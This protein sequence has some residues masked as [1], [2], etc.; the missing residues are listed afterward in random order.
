MRF[1]WL[2]K[3]PAQ[4]CLLAGMLA[5]VSFSSTQ[6]ALTPAGTHIDNRADGSYLNAGGGTE[7]FSSGTVKVIVQSLDLIEL[8]TNRTV[9]ATANSPVSFAHTLRNLGNGTTT[10]TVSFSN[11]TGD[12]FD[13]TDLALYRDLNG[14]GLADAGEPLLS[15]AARSSKAAAASAS[16]LD[17][18]ITLTLGAAESVNLILAA[19]TPASGLPGQSGQLQLLA[20]VEGQS[21]QAVNTDTVTLINITPTI[22]LAKAASATTASRNQK[23]TFTL[24]GSNSDGGTAMGV[25]V[26]IDGTN[27]SLVVI[28]DA[29]PRNTTFAA[30]ADAGTSRVLYHYAGEAFHAYHTVPAASLNL[31][32]AVGFDYASIPV[33]ESFSVAFK[34][35]VN[36]AASGGFTNIAAIHYFDGVTDKAVD[37]NPVFISTPTVPPTIH[38][39][40]GSD[41]GTIANVTRLGQPLFVQADAAF[42][43][44]NTGTME[45]RTITI[46]STK[47]G[48]IET[49][50][51]FE[52]SVNSGTFRILPSVPTQNAL[53]HTPNAGDGILQTVKNDVLKA[54]ISGCEGTTAISTVLIDPFGVVFNSANNELIAGATVTLIDVTGAGNGGRPNEPAKVLQPDAITEAPSTVTTGPDGQ[55]QFPL[56]APSL[57]RL[58]IVAPTSY[59]FPST[60]Q[61]ANLPSGRSIDGSGSYGGDFPVDAGTGAVNIDVPVDPSPGAGAILIEKTAS[62][63]IAEIGDLVIYSIKIRNTTSLSF[64]GL[65]MSDDLPAGF[66]Y[67]KGSARLDRAIIADPTGGAGPRL[68]FALGTMAP[69]AILTLDYRVRV[70]VGAFQGNG[71]NRAQA[72][73][74]FPRTISNVSAVQVKM[75]KGVFTD[76]GIMIG[77]I[78]VD[79]NEDGVQDEGDLGIPGVRL[80]LE[81]GNF[82]IS[83]S[84]GKYSMYGLS[85][86]THVLKVDNTTLPPGSRL[87]AFSTRHALDGGSRFVDLKNAEL[88]KANFAVASSQE[89]LANVMARRKKGEVEVAEIEKNVKERL[90]TDNERVNNAD[91]KAMPAAGL[92]GDKNTS[93]VVQPVTPATVTTNA[94]PR[95]KKSVSPVSVE[96]N[97]PAS[98]SFNSVLPINTL[99]SDNSNLPT[100]PRAMT[101]YVD[102][103]NVVTNLPDNTLAFLDF[104]NGDT[105]PSAITDVR[106][107]GPAGG[108]FAL[109]VNGEEISSKRVGKQAIAADKQVQAWEFIAVRLKAGTNDLELV[110]KDSF[111]NERGKVVVSV[112][113]PDKLGRIKITLPKKEAPADGVTPLKVIVELT[114]A[115]GLPV[116]SRTPLILEASAGRWDVH[117]LD[118]AEPGIQVFIEG[119]HAEYKLLPPTDPVNSMIRVSSGML[120]QE[121]EMIFLPDLRPLIASG[122]IEGTINL[123]SISATSLVPTRSRDGFEEELRGFA[124]TSGDGKIHGG[125]RAAFFLKGKIK[126]D[127]L[128]TAGY[129]S[130]KDTQERLF[131]DI[132]PDKFYPVYGDSSVKGFEAQSTGRLYVRVD[133]KKSYL[134]YGD[135]TTAA[136]NTEVRSLG[137]YNRSLTG[138]REHY[139]NKRVSANVW[140][141]ED[142]T[143]QV[144]EEIRANGTSGP[145]GFHTGNAIVNSEKVEIITRDRNQSSFIIKTVPMERFT[146]YEFEPFTGQ[147][148][149]KAPV[150]SLDE[151]LNPIFIRVT[152]ET[153]TNG[154]RFWVYGGDAQVKVTDR[155]EVGGSAVR[156]E[157]PADNYELYSANSTFKLGKQTYLFG[158]VAQSDS[159]VQGTGNA[160]RVELRHKGEKTDARLYYGRTDDT[161][162]NSSALLMPGRVE[163]GLKLTQRLNETTRLILEGIY[164]EDSAFGGNRKGARVGVEKA[165]EGNYRVELGARYSTETGSPASTNM[166][167]ATPNEVRSVRLKVTAPVP[168]LK[169]ASVYGEYENDVTEVDK[170]MVAFGADYQLKNKG[171][172]YARHEFI[173]AVGGPFELNNFQEQ[174][175]TVFGADFEYMKDG[176]YFNEY[177]A[178]D[179]FSGRE[180]EAAIGLRNGWNVAEGVKLS[181][182]FERVTPIQGGTMQNESTAATGGIEYTRNP[183][184]KGTARLE[185]R[186]SDS[187]DSLLNSLGYA[188]KVSQD[189]TFLTRT[190]LYLTDNKTAGSTDR[191]QGRFQAGMAYRQTETDRWNALGKYEFRFEDGAVS[192]LFGGAIGSSM[193]ERRQVHIVSLDVNY[194]PTENWILNGHYAGKLAMD[195]VPVTD[196]YHAHLV[197]GRAIYEITD[198]W[199]VGLNAN[200]LFSGKLDSIQYGVG[201]EIG[202]TLKKN[203]R[204]GVGY[205]VF[206]FRDR[207]L[208]AENYTDRGVYVHLRLK[209]DERAFGWLRSRKGEE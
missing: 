10:Y 195:S 67:Q 25:P 6:A 163:S 91:Y 193:V 26:T 171:K 194:Q 191:V 188:R 3:I 35:Q 185:L 7:H 44:T 124:A 109:K 184:W 102:L 86:R 24:S 38:Y 175:A 13:L 208:S 183:D 137:N 48:D 108:A 152:F 125:G 5:H 19:K 14:N 30:V 145:Y 122:V 167:G 92:I 165:F 111:G 103:E 135:F 42:C 9:T 182:T 149:F 129:D 161:F 66:S 209:F 95:T 173:N 2:K 131:R 105:L 158:E 206:G 84:E 39:Y 27:A 89:V 106:V 204:V 190:L 139:E 176:R 96:T 16:A 71:I 64:S 8:L 68:E 127:F 69:G 57:Y 174:N 76:K 20:K 50:E 45:T 199:D 157:N 28:R 155:L 186:S 11:V 87:I 34:V 56:V 101:P 140:A 98:S 97:G 196:S 21:I 130:D 70:G 151:N 198:R 170:K 55:Y 36:S 117:D 75:D 12:H 17:E 82:V 62:R 154:E 83:D 22:S 1:G 200:A 110:Q 141:S 47:T 121:A 160:G 178:R 156:D 172:L 52:S 189:W 93:G 90:P 49:F 179:S 41:F 72:R 78:F 147:L 205:N 73:T 166:I 40:T 80:Y 142:S 37:S 60:I 54:T 61:P 119:G 148:L 164:T 53:E 123:R 207:D 23:V 79:M 177:R 144:T 29:L 197:G 32:D 159:D 153:E 116:T 133:K 126:G 180:S 100:S 187:M 104:K 115:Q 113:A 202:F 169:N 114:D 138:I 94:L 18:G 136:S 4:L 162:T 107:K 51:A 74:I 77:K 118:K 128:L 112:L 132:E 46:A 65:T 81:N 88:H 143:R 58:Q 168:K 59:S 63:S 192:S 120:E 85:P 31:I 134:L 150:P 181:T 43:N 15:T 146:D 203:L 99:N 33:G 201:P